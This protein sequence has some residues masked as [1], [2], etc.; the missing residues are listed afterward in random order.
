M[1]HCAA[2]R[3]VWVTARDFNQIIVDIDR[4][5][6]I[7][8]DRQLASP[9]RPLAQPIDCPICAATMSRAN[10]GRKSGV[11]VDSC[12]KHGIWFDAGELRRVVAY[13]RAQARRYELDRSP[14]ELGLE[15]DE[16][17][18]RIAALLA[19]SR[20]RDEA[21]LWKAVLDALLKVLTS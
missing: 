3:G 10:F 21:P 18:A 2:C 5:D 1:H 4:Q 12:R 17:E 16:L 9:L 20:T 14:E 7:L 19:E 11:L 13:L 8:S 15:A 6:Q